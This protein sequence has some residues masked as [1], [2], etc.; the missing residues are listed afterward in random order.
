M[1]RRIN[2]VRENSLLK[3]FFKISINLNNL[4][5]IIKSKSYKIKIN[6]KNLKLL[7]SN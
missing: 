4:Y 6:K 1:C 5:D 3:I 7:N 2:K